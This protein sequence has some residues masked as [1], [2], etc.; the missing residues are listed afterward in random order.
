M[1]NEQS[2]RWL[3]LRYI[4]GKKEKARQWVPSVRPTADTTSKEKIFKEDICMCISV[5]TRFSTLSET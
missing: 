1:L 5:S 4:Q 3:K 2:Y